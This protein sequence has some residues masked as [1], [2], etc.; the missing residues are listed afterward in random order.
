MSLPL[1]SLLF[2]VLWTAGMLWWNA[3]LDAAEAVIFIVAGAIA[4]V[5]W[6]YLMRKYTNWLQQRRDRNASGT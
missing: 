3:P 6:Y 4:G 5:L 1:S 2:A